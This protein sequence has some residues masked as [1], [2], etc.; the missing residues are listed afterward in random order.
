MALWKNQQ[1]L[2]TFLLMSLTYPCK[3]LVEVHHGSMGR[4][5]FITELSTTWLEQ[6]FLTVFNMKIN[7]VVQ[8]KHLLKSIYENS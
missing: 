8:L 6:P 1:I 7:D 4:I 5:N 3:I 2:L